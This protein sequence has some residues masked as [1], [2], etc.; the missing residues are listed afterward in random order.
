MPWQATDDS[1]DLVRSVRALFGSSDRFLGSMAVDFLELEPR[2]ESIRHN[3]SFSPRPGG[4]GAKPQPRKSK[5]SGSGNPAKRAAAQAAALEAAREEE[6]MS[7]VVFTSDEMARLCRLTT[8]TFDFGLA[9]GQAMSGETGPL[10]DL[11]PWGDDTMPSA[12]VMTDSQKAVAKRFGGYMAKAEALPVE[13]LAH[14]H[15]LQRHWIMQATRATINARL[16]TVEEYLG[17]LYASRLRSVSDRAGVQRAF[18]RPLKVTEDTEDKK[19]INLR[20]GLL[21]HWQGQLRTIPTLSR[22]TVHLNSRS[23]L[24]RQLGRFVPAT[25][26]NQIRP[27]PTDKQLMDVKDEI[28]KVNFRYTTI[29]DTWE[30]NFDEFVRLYA[31]QVKAVQ[32]AGEPYVERLRQIPSESQD[33]ALPWLNLETDDPRRGEVVEAAR[34]LSRLLPDIDR[35]RA[36]KTVSLAVHLRD[37]AL[38]SDQAVIDQVALGFLGAVKHELVLL[39]DFDDTTQALEAYGLTIPYDVAREAPLREVFEQLLT[40]WQDICDVMRYDTSG[41]QVR[42]AFDTVQAWL[43]KARR[44]TDRDLTPAP[45]DEESEG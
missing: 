18:S 8:R 24:V 17:G 11:A 23:R 32:E 25:F 19:F 3:L 33:A 42:V 2:F 29:G 41:S 31:P 16:A 37:G 38:S 6:R 15:P 10:K 14:L 21:L 36:T 22:E 1:L 13:E 20:H 12:E 30:D 35:D 45:A 40:H 26:D 5:R 7:S 34:L 43:L 27:G 9:L 44:L 4:S 39:Q 28:R